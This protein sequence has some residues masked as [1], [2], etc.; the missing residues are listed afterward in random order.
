MITNEQEFWVHLGASRGTNMKV[1]VM[2]LWGLLWFS[3]FLNFP[4]IH[5]YGDSRTIIEHV[6]G[7]IKINQPMLLGWL[8]QI[9]NL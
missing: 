9:E 3:S 8:S 1:E 6:K 5:I 4:T 7:S 2:A